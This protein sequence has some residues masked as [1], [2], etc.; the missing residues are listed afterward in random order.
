MPLSEQTRDRARAII[1]R[2]PRSRSAL[3]PMLHLVQAEE[4]YVTPAGIALCAEEL[5]LTKAE[6]GAVATFYTMYKR[7]PTG[8][9]LVSV[10]TNIACQ[11]RGGEEIYACVKAELGVG[12]NETTED[13]TITLE[14]AECLAACDFAP[15]VTVNYEF[16]DNQTPETALD[17]VK[18]LQS[19]NVP[20]P[21]RGETP[22]TFREVE[23]ELAG[24]YE[25]AA[26]TDGG[27]HP[28]IVERIKN[29][30]R[31]ADA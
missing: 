28:G 21:D 5:G 2:Y 3:L 20:M 8:D 9:Y 6:V 15:V 23:M 31:K 18:G 26:D 30:V 22:R 17:I 24:F 16:Y 13:G 7:R 27:D 25:P 4:G 19:G 11:L 1:A 29:V 14:H 10:C 12:H